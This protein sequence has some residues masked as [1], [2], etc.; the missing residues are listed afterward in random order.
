MCRQKRREYLEGLPQDT[1][2]WHDRLTQ[3]E[4][5]CFAEYHGHA[6]GASFFISGFEPMVSRI[7][8][9]ALAG[10]GLIEGVVTEKP[11]SFFI[12]VRG[13]PHAYQKEMHQPFQYACFFWGFGVHFFRSAGNTTKS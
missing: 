6:R 12:S 13:F 11:P 2:R 3:V 9:P 5:F 1:M 8:G 7:V 4:V 10:R